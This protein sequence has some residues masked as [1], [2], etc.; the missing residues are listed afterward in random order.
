[1]KNVSQMYISTNNE[2]WKQSIKPL[3]IH[4]ETDRERMREHVMQ[5]EG[6]GKIQMEYKECLILLF[7]WKCSMC[8]IFV[9]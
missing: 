3:K 8:N 7:R 9:Q 4:K 2:W 5:G 6:D 1:M